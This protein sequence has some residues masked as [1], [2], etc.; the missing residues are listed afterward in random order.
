[1]TT[2]HAF[3]RDDAS[4][5]G[6]EQ[7]EKTVVNGGPGSVDA[8]YQA[9]LEAYVVRARRVEEHSLAADW[10]ALVALAN[11][12][13]S[14]V[15]LDNGETRIRQEF[16]AEEVVESAA[17]RLRPILLE[18]DACFYLKA[19]K[20]LG[21]FCR[22]LPQDTQWVKTTRD[23]WQARVRPTTPEEAGYWV[24]LSNMVTGENRSLDR[25]KLAMAWIYGDV[26]H[27]DMEQR[28]EGDAFGL[29]ERFRGAVPLVAW[30]MI[31][32]IELL[33]Y[34]RALHD[35]GVLQLRQEVFDER[36]ALKSTTWERNGQIFFAPVGT[37]TPTNASTPVPDEWVRLGEGA[38][39]SRF[40]TVFGGQLLH[41]DR[42]PRM[43][44]TPSP[45]EIEAARTPAGG[46]KRDQLAAWGVSW[47]PPKGW[48]DELT[49]RWKAAHQDGAPPP[50][51][52]PAA[53]VQ[54]SLDFG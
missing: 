36:V 42:S 1:M 38:D 32:T 27:H 41:A 9:W 34:I 33:N 10:D 21:Y 14:V 31:G 18:G 6:C 22:A 30:A 26:V 29:F 45:E 11:I 24:A 43:P 19:L 52:A 13:I 54:E 5:S 35:D 48:K 15:Q 16:P 28:Q 37:E 17:A 44:E 47:P 39:L 2:R 8:Q 23:E 46:W 20:A 40:Q 3:P 53:S 12:Q 51:P 4:D 49:E 50:R 7:W 25:H